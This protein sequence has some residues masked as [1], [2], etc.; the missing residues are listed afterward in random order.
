MKKSGFAR[1]GE[2]V[3]PLKNVHF[4]SSSRKG[5]FLTT[6][7]RSAGPTGQAGIHLVFRGLKFEPDVEIGQK[8]GFYKGL[9]AIDEH[10]RYR[11]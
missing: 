6:P 10:C 5:E 1:T 3:R 2:K 7:V 8:G 11:T 9:K 4:Y